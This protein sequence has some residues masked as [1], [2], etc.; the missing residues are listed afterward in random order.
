MYWIDLSGGT[1][2]RNERCLYLVGTLREASAAFGGNACHVAG[3]G[4]SVRHGKA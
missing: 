2:P 3:R 4:W 1:S